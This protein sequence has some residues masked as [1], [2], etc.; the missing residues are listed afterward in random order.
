M[1]DFELIVYIIAALI[2]FVS[3]NYRKVQQNRPGQN[4]EPTPVPQMQKPVPVQTKRKKET[5]AVPA[6][7]QPSEKIPYRAMK[8]QNLAKEYKPVR[9]SQS[10]DFLKTEIESTQNFFKNILPS[11]DQTQ[12]VHLQQPEDLRPYLMPDDLKKAIIY[13]EIIRRPYN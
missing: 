7:S 12:S 9:K 13:A 1:K 3:K 2:Y 8:R 4:P 5:V 11:E 6:Q 10:P